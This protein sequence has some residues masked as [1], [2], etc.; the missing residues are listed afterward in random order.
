MSKTWGTGLFYPRFDKCPRLPTSRLYINWVICVNSRSKHI[1]FGNQQIYLHVDI[2]IYIS[3][4]PFV[5]KVENM[6]DAEFTLP[7]I[8]FDVELVCN[9]A[10]LPQQPH[11]IHKTSFAKTKFVSAHPILPLILSLD[12]YGNISLWDSQLKQIVWA[13]SG[14]QLQKE[15][16]LQ[17][18]HAQIPSKDEHKKFAARSKHASLARLNG[19][20]LRNMGNIA[21]PHMTP[22]PFDSYSA[23]SAVPNEVLK[24]FLGDIKAVDFSDPEYILAQGGKNLQF[25]HL[26]LSTIET[27]AQHRLTFLFDQAIVV[28]NYQQGKVLS[29]LKLNTDLAN[30]LMKPTCWE[31][32]TA[33][34]LAVGAAD[35]HVRVFEDQSLAAPWK[36]ANVPGGSGGRVLGQLAPKNLYKTMNLIHTFSIHQFANTCTYQP[37]SASFPAPTASTGEVSILRTIPSVMEILPNTSSGDGWSQNNDEYE[38]RSEEDDLLLSLQAASQH[39]VQLLSVSSDGSIFAWRLTYFSTLQVPSLSLGGASLESGFVGT[40]QP[41]ARLSEGILGGLS[42]ASTIANLSSTNVADNSNMAAATG[43]ENASLGATNYHVGGITLQ[44]AA[45]NS[46]TVIISNPI[47]ARYDRQHRLLI[48]YP[49]QESSLVQQSQTAIWESLSLAALRLRACPLKIRSMTLQVLV[50]EGVVRV[51]DLTAMFL[52]PV[53]LQPDVSHW[54]PS[55][56]QLPTSPP[57]PNGTSIGVRRNSGS[58]SNHFSSSPSKRVN[59][60]DGFDSTTANAV[61]VSV[62]A[63]G[64]KDSKKSTS[65]LASVFTK[66]RGSITNPSFSVPSSSAHAAVGVG[67]VENTSSAFQSGNNLHTSDPVILHLSAYAA[68]KPGKTFSDNLRKH[69]L[70]T[71]GL[72]SFP[73]PSA[74]RPL[75]S[76]LYLYPAKHDEL[77]IVYNTHMAH[78]LFH[79]HRQHLQWQQRLLHSLHCDVLDLGDAYANILASLEPFVPAPPSSSSSSSSSSSRWNTVNNNM[80]GTTTNSSTNNNHWNVYSVHTNMEFFGVEDFHF[81]DPENDDNDRS[82]VDK[83]SAASSLA[84]APTHIARTSS[85][86]LKR[87]SSSQMRMNMNTTTATATAATSNITIHSTA[88]AWNIYGVNVKQVSAWRLE[89]VQTWTP[90]TEAVVSTHSFLSFFF[91]F[92]WA[93]F[94]LALL[95][96][97]FV[98]MFVWFFAYLLF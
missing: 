81:H 82:L 53:L 89:S 75:I 67:K 63:S 66:S 40:E 22:M 10:L 59:A 96:V 55:A 80:T 83:G 87:R 77:A 97:W 58:L 29:I 90:I 17:A 84:P 26:N 56:A 12:E 36:S 65:L 4:P 93:P 85:L 11:P 23:L 62:S 50:S 16:I 44:Q 79:H 19:P 72:A 91:S 39:T 41:I 47:P 95:L 52:L 3:S 43:G 35:G 38:S 32:L 9:S 88:G 49:Y 64:K 15:A 94:T 98:C 14:F 60:P 20:A 34:H 70:S 51:F 5:W 24:D 54:F 25:P 33:A 1:S 45:L 37:T 74:A 61:S 2:Y 6:S 57:D 31:W 42:P 28:Y 8:K 69:G 71:T 78:A 30:K 27:S 48:D 86:G 18:Y 46:Q 7:S 21:I 73:F 92:F 13:S 68:L 76:G